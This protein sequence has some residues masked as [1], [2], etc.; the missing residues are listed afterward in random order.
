[1]KIARQ[2]SKFERLKD[3]LGLWGVT[4]AIFAI[5]L[6]PTWVYLLAR[7]L[8]NPDNALVEILLFGISLYFMGAVQIFAL[9]IAVIIVVTLWNEA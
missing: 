4:I 7:F 3:L 8:F 6:I 1:M 2:K 5:A 9:I